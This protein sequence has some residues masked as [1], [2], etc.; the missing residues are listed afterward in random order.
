MKELGAACEQ[1]I[2]KVK[3][4]R[5]IVKVELEFRII[6]LGTQLR[7]RQL[8]TSLAYVESVANL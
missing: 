4:L 8:H 3:F 6:I 2:I 7:E 5:D 1:L